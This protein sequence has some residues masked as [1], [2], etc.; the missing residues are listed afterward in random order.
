MGDLLEIAMVNDCRVFFEKNSD[1]R[2]R[3]FFTAYVQLPNSG[4]F[5]IDDPILPRLKR[6]LTDVI[7]RVH[8]PMRAVSGSLESLSEVFE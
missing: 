6:R 1:S 7:E 2:Q 4:Q 3:M 5:I 8:G